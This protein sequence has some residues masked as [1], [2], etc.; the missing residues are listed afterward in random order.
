[1][2]VNF[3][4]LTCRR[5]Q[6]R[7]EN[8]PYQLRQRNANKARQPS[9]KNKSKLMRNQSKE[10]LIADKH[11]IIQGAQLLKTISNTLQNIKTD[12]KTYD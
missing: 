9:R 1:M 12:E 7:V 2:D 10:T 11:P 8:V 4:S 5:M 6:R 3:N